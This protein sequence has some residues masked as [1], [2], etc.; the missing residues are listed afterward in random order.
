MVSGKVLGLVALAAVATTGVAWAV[1]NAGALQGGGQAKAFAIGADGQ[2]R[3]SA[4]YGFFE[5]VRIGTIV[6]KPNPRTIQLFVNGKPGGSIHDWDP[7]T[8]NNYIIEVA[9]GIIPEGSWNV[10][11]ETTFGDGTKLRSNTVSVKIVASSVV[12]GPGT[13]NVG[14]YEP[15]V[16]PRG[17]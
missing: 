4:T 10:S 17:Y 9:P 5:A 16:S 2:Y 7:S 3:A 8:G 13:I 15:Y 6:N 12:I 11:T 14:A 1:M